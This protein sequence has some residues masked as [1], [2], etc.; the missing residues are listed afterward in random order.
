MV[1]TQQDSVGQV[2]SSATRP[3]DEVVSFAPRGWPV[4]SRESAPAIPSSEPLPL[5]GVVESHRAAE[6]NDLPIPVEA[7]GQRTRL[8]D[9]ALD[10]GDAHRLALALD[11]TQ[12][13]ASAQV[14]VGD[15]YLNGG[16]AAPEHHSRVGHRARAQNLG[17][18]VERDLLRGAVVG[19]HPFGAGHGAGVYEARS[20][21]SR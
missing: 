19:E 12:A 16:G 13:H 21:A 18:R 4:A 8:A 5:T 14:V 9:V 1:A 7:N 2:S 15:E 20:S 17:E 10:R 6:I 3:F 11:V